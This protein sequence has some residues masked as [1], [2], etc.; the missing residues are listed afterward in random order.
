MSHITAENCIATWDARLMRESH[1]ALGQDGKPFAAWKDGS[2]KPRHYTNFDADQ[3]YG[4]FSS[5]RIDYGPTKGPFVYGCI[6][7]HVAR[8]RLNRFR[9]L[10]AVG[11]R[12]PQDG[13]FENC[14][15]FV[16][17]GRPD[18]RP[19]QSAVLRSAAAACR[20]RW[21][22][23]HLRVRDVV[24]R[25]ERREEGPSRKSLARASVQQ[26]E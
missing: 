25:L 6:A 3:P 26:G 13:W 16:E 2:G 15:V 24:S 19:V 5:D 18:I 4:C 14:A 23:R 8:Q 9:A 21:G 7:Y 20:R 11:C 1:S 22:A 17:P 10:L 12:Q